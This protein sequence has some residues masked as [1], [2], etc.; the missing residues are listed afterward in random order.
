[1]KSVS[2]QSL[3]KRG[4]GVIFFFFFLFCWFGGVLGF[5]FLKVRLK[6]LTNTLAE[7]PDPSF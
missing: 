6:Q 3:G 5:F 4:R 2:V 7:V 1:M